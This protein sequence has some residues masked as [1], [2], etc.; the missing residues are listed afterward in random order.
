MLLIVATMFSLQ[1]PRTAQAIC[2]DQLKYLQKLLCIYSS[3]LRSGCGQKL[4]IHCE[5]ALTSQPQALGMVEVA[6]RLW[7]LQGWRCFI[8]S[9]RQMQPFIFGVEKVFT[10]INL[11]A[12]N[13]FSED[14]QFKTVLKKEFEFFNHH[15]WFNVRW[16]YTATPIDRF[17]ITKAG[18]DAITV[19]IVGHIW[20]NLSD[21]EWSAN[22]YGWE[23]NWRKVK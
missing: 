14:I 10:L 9:D 1:Q 23:T 20:D 18:G 4:F 8:W 11:G 21:E 19:Q 3:H 13:I 5:H 15:W 17:E 22:N 12:L 6:V 7:P 16:C 2:L